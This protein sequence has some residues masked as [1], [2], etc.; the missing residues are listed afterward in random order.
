MYT[1]WLLPC[2]QTCLA[3]FLEALEIERA[4]D[5]YFSW[6]S[7]NTIVLAVDFVSEETAVACNHHET[8]LV[9]DAVIVA[10]H[11]HLG[12]DNA[13]LAVLDADP[14]WRFGLENQSRFAVGGGQFWRLCEEMTGAGIAGGSRRGG[15]RGAHHGAWTHTM[16]VFQGR[17]DW[18]QVRQVKE[19]VRVPVIVNGDIRRRGCA[20]RARG[21]GR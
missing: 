7:E 20:R 14:H 18:A 3:A 8:L 19:A 5:Q 12:D 2:A 6:R 9:R 10:G 13:A 1:P 11:E 16:P 15:R 21:I 4:S 17:A